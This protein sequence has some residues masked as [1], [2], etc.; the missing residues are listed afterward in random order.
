MFLKQINAEF[1]KV[2]LPKFGK[3]AFEKCIAIYYTF[4]FIACIRQSLPHLRFSAI[5]IYLGLLVVNI[6]P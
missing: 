4:T 6:I 3:N 1:N 2:D 5:E